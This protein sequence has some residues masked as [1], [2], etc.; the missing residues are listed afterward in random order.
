MNAVYSYKIVDSAL[1]DADRKKRIVKGYFAAFNIKDSDGDIIRPGAFAKTIAENGPDSTRP[2]I[3]HIL[4]HWP[5]QPLG[6]LKSLTEDA[7]GLLYESEIGTHDLGNDFLK[8]VDSGL[9]TE[10][11]IGYRIMKEEQDRENEINYLN[12][13]KLWEG[14]SLTAWGANE[15]TPLVS[16]KGNDVDMLEKKMAAIEDFCKNSDATDET[17]E[18]LLLQV[19]QLHQ[20]IID[21]KNSTEPR[22]GTQ[23]RKDMGEKY[24]K[25][26]SDIHALFV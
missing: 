18:L 10:H 21:L 14:S 1:K 6:R 8:M 4:N 15:F 23:P 19:K 26:I 17:I 2:R 25:A 22:I 13:L 24:A 7:H 16:A 11:S 5:S 3:K 20:Y 9:I 12:E